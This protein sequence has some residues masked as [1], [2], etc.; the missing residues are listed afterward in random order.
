LC[1][2]WSTTLASSVRERLTVAHPSIWRLAI[3][4]GAT[5]L[6]LGDEILALNVNTPA[7]LERAAALTDYHWWAATTDA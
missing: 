4:L 5:S 2:V 7:D 3:E 1:S 6:S